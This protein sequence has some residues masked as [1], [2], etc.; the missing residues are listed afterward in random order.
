LLSL[1][2]IKNA[3][4]QSAF[5]IFWRVVALAA[6]A[7]SPSNSISIMPMLFRFR[8]YSKNHKKN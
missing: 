4:M 6:G 2:W 5:G 3:N 8:T 7:V 1:R